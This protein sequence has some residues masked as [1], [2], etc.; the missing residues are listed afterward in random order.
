MSAVLRLTV[1]GCGSSGGVPRLGGI[2]GACDPTNPKNRRRRCSVLVERIEGENVTRVLIDT[3]PDMRDQLLGAEVGHL[4][5]VVFT[6]EHAD[7]T[8][9]LDDLRMIVFNRKSRLPVWADP[10]TADSLIGRFSYAFVQPTGSDYPPILDLIGIGSD[11]FTVDGAAGPLTFQ[12]FKVKHGQID[13]LGFRV[14]NLAYLPDAQEIYEDSWPTLEGLDVWVVD[15]LRYTP[16]PSHAH[17]ERT[18]GWIERARPK[19]AVLTNLHIDMDYE[20]LDGELP[21]NITPAFDG[22]VIEIPL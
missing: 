16:H 1:L 6:H 5:G 19:Q 10:Y 17:L 9:G 4:D 21:D 14:G 20:T 12:P 7:H 3:S 22:K 18:L 11:P 8:H 2:W 13:S 15:A